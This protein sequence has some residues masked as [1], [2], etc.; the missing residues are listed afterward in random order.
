MPAQQSSQ[1]LLA[2]PFDFHCLHPD[3]KHQINQI[4]SFYNLQGYQLHQAALETYFGTYYDQ[5]PK[6]H[7]PLPEN[8][9]SSHM[10]GGSIAQGSSEKSQQAIHYGQ[11]HFA[12]GEPGPSAGLHGSGLATGLVEGIAGLLGGCCQTCFS[13]CTF[14]VP[15]GYQLVPAPSAFDYGATTGYEVEKRP[16]VNVAQQDVYVPTTIPPNESTAFSSA[17]SGLMGTYVTSYQSARESPNQALTAPP[18]VS[19]NLVYTDIPVP[20]YY[21]NAPNA[22]APDASQNSSGITSHPASTNDLLSTPYNAALVGPSLPPTM[23][24]QR[25]L[26][27]VASEYPYP[28]PEMCVKDE[29]IGQSGS[30]SRLDIVYSHQ[31]APASKRGPFKDIRQRQE[32]ANT[33][34]IG[35]CV[36]CK[37]QRIRCVPDPDDETACCLTCKPKANSIH[38]K[39][40]SRLPCI[41]AKLTDVKCMKPGQVHGFEW[42]LRWGDNGPV[43]NIAN[44]ASS[45]VKIIRVTEGYARGMSVQLHV[46]EFIPQ[47]GDKLERSWVGP[48]G[49]KKSVPI[50]PYAITDLDEAQ[51]AYQDYIKRGVVDCFSS[52]VEGVMGA[53]D[54]LLFTTYS[55][56]WQLSQDPR[57]SPEERELL[58]QTLELWVAVRLTTKSVEIVG[59]ETLGMDRNILDNSSPQH[60]KIPL[61]PV[62]GAQLDLVL[63]QHIQTR[64]RRDMLEKL[65]KMTQQNKQK[66]WLTTYLVTFILLHNIAL[67]ANHDASYA[68]KHGMKTKFAREAD[69]QEY[70]WGGTILLAYF[71]YCNKNVAPFSE[72]CRDQDLRQLAQLDEQAIQFVHWTRSQVMA[73]RNEWDELYEDNAYEKPYFFVSQLFQR[74]WRPQDWSAHDLEPRNVENCAC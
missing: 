74:D 11:H 25:D 18:A 6:R 45:D 21:T 24:H 67:L 50:P 23:Q 70:H 31:R 63:I 65:Q 36:R 15:E 20:T 62:M 48:D 71:H 35:S 49:S 12:D 33:R 30:A 22:S 7:R 57:I 41:R 8:S 37:M 19:D 54:H 2:P 72:D 61:P 9:M 53:R 13:P 69:V 43:D 38:H 34:K 68:R 55:K 51:A 47:P 4:A 56:A 59:N 52:L 29:D 10:P 66:T 3:L 27:A 14:T 32:T 1:P 44:W 60:G 40:L 64:L 28:M 46:R 5:P 42:T 58:T 73:H 26:A 39:H 16:S 17:D